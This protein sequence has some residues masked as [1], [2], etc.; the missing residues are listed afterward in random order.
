MN[1]ALIALLPKKDGAVDLK[2]FRPISLVH[3]FAKLVAKL[4]ALRLA[5]RMAELVST[6]QSAFIR[7]RC[8]HDN[9]V[10]VRQSA[11]ALHRRKTPALLF[12]LD[13]ARAFDSVS[14]PF[15]LSVLQQRGFGPGWIRW[16]SMLLRTASTRV[17]VNGAAGSA[18]SHGRGLRQGDPL[19]PL[20]FVLVMD[21]LSAM[22]R[23]AERAGVLPPL[24]AGLRHRVSL[25]ADDVVVFAAPSTAELSVVKGILQCFGDGS[26]LHVNFQKSSVAPIQCSQEVVDHVSASIDCP[27]RQLPCTYLGLPLS[28]KKLRKEDLQLVLEKLA[29]KLAFWKAKL[30]TKDGRVA[31]VQAVMTAS[32]IY[33]L[34]ALDIEPWFFKA[35][36]R[37]R[38]GFL[39]AGKPDARGGCC[40]VA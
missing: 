11:V 10:L 37:L 4:M 36:D 7:G 16:I 2:E 23:A 22:F 39:W 20:L 26:G 33:Q 35:V 29:R 6:N 34:M 17:L 14:W 1:G 3:S 15:L 28:L 25:Y 18:F 32:V 31:F 19:S 13:V 30:L 9:F 21:V 8:I 12:K 5:P 40:L 27:I 24:P 38:R